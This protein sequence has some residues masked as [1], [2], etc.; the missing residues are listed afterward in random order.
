M[1]KNYFS[2]FQQLLSM[3]VFKQLV[4]IWA[5][6]GSRV[7]QLLIIIPCSHGQTNIPINQPFYQTTTEA[8]R[9]NQTTSIMGSCLGKHWSFPPQ[10]EQD[11]SAALG[12]V[13]VAG[14]SSNAKSELVITRSHF[15]LSATAAMENKNYSTLLSLELLAD[16]EEDSMRTGFQYDCKIFT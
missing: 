5:L 7:A 6:T 2:H 8:R 14:V 13:P 4:T 11:K 9:N 16:R 12:M 1:S 15:K 10:E 3:L